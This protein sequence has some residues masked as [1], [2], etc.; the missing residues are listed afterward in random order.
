MATFS[1]LEKGRIALIRQLDN[2][3][4]QQIGLTKEH[5]DMLQ[6]FLASMSKEYKFIAMPEEY[7]LV[8]K[9]QL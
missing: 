5:S 7:N 4:I 6:L 2:G 3:D 9:S 8:L 1:E